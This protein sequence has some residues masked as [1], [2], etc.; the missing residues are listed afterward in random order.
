MNFFKLKDIFINHCPP[1]R[2]INVNL[3]SLRAFDEKEINCSFLLEKPS[4]KIK[5]FS[6][7]NSQ[8][9]QTQYRSVCSPNYRCGGSVG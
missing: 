2:S 5:Y 1:Q 8:A 9:L 7:A 4:Q 6:V 3:G